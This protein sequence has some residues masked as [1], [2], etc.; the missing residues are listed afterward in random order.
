MATKTIENLEVNDVLYL[1]LPGLPE[2]EI[3]EVKVVSIGIVKSNIKYREIKFLRPSKDKRITDDN[4]LDAN[5]IHGTKVTQ[6]I[7][8]PG[9]ST[10]CTLNTNPPTVICTS[11]QELE[12]W[13]R[14]T[15]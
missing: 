14:T 12:K 9:K 10:M 3:A 8:V 4:L 1:L 2:P 6:T 5:K 13:M 7:I 11:K 15:K